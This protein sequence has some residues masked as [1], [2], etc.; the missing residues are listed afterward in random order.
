MIVAGHAIV[1]RNGRKIAE[2]GS[3]DILGELGLLLRRDHVTTVTAATPLEVLVLP[4]HALR[5]AV[6]EIPGLGWKLLQTVAERL[7]DSSTGLS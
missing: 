6:D 7:S 4:Q 5:Q 3:G 2:R 1:R